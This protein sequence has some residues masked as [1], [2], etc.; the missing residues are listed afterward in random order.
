M[1]ISD[2]PGIRILLPEKGHHEEKQWC[3]FFPIP[4]KVFIL[5]KVLTP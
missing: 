2:D 1:Q 3:H 4:G 5:T